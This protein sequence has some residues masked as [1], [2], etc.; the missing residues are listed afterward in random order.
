[1]LGGGSH[2]F[3]VKLQQTDD[4][5]RGIMSAAVCRPVVLSL[6][7]KLLNHPQHRIRGAADARRPAA[8]IDVMSDRDSQS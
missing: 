5:P 6:P 8:R 2:G 1:V 4:A 3:E 7:G